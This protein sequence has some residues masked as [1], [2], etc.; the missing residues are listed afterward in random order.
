M[1]IAKNGEI[2]MREE[3][4]EEE[5]KKYQ[6]HLKVL[7]EEKTRN[8]EKSNLKLQ[9]EIGERRRTQ[10]ALQLLNEELEQ[11]VDMRTSELK[12]A[13]KT[14]LLK[15]RLATLGELSSRVSHELRNPLGVIKNA[16]YF[17]KMRVETFK[18][19][20]VRENIKISISTAARGCCFERP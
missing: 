13:H 1:I 18:D 14:L 7:V 6:D 11:R 9:E 15:E 5:L 10:E 12:K 16:I 8:L 17:F 4:T 20:A 3:L 2:P 19:A